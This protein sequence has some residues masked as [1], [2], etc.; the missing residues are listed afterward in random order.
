MTSRVLPVSEWPRLDGTLL[1]SVWPTLDPTYAEV[2]VVEDAA[3]AIVA[4]VVLLTTLHAECLSVQGGV[5]VARALW[6]ALR[7]RV[8]AAG[9]QAVWGAALDDPMRNLLTRHAEPIPGEHF[10]MRMH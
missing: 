1:E 8:R 9:G 3:G 6:S 5:S 10:V 7:A 2:L 4:S